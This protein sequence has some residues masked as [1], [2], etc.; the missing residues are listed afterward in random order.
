MKQEP[1]YAPQYSARERWLHALIGIG[2]AAVILAVCKWWAF[3]EL[4]MFAQTAHCR[5]IL[6]IPGTSVLMYGVFVGL[7]LAASISIAAFVAP[8][9]IRSIRMR[10]YP[11]PGVKVHGKVKV[12][13][14][15]SARLAVIRDLLAPVALGCIAVWGGFQASELTRSLKA[16]ASYPDCKAYLE[17][18]G[19]RTDNTRF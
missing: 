3:P 15:P 11:P 5:T 1:E 14:G 9:A 8:L 19:T 17:K 18:M 7:P 10:E 16:P 12:R 4:R 2:S 13:K 6:G